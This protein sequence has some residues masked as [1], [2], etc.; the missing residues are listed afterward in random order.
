RA[1]DLCTILNKRC[2]YAFGFLSF[3]AQELRGTS[4]VLDGKPH[5]FRGRLARP[6]PACARLGL[7]ALHGG[8]EA[9][10]VDADLALAQ[11]ILRQIEWEAVGVVELEGRLT[12]ETVARAKRGRGIGKQVEAACQCLAE[13][14]FLKL[15]RLG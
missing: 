4:L 7:L 6:G 3:V 12:I 9:F 10:E 8:I 5:S 2:D 15:E 13:A 11:R 14:C 1:L